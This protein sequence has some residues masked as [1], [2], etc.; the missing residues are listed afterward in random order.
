MD[1]VGLLNLPDTRAT[2]QHHYVKDRAAN[3][4]RRR[5]GVAA[6]FWKD[7]SVTVAVHSCAYFFNL[8][9]KILENSNHVFRMLLK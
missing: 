7:N 6:R 8:C 5:S 3:M 2:S 4:M 1:S 9:F